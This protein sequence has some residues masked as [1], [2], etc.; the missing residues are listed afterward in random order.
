M[1]FPSLLAL[2]MLPPAVAPFAGDMLIDA[3]SRAE[4]DSP[5]APDQNPQVAAYGRVFRVP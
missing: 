1:P 3:S 2:S 5:L 4:D